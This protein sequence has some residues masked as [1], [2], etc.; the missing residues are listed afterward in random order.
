MSTC[1]WSRHAQFRS[2]SNLSA[3]V[4]RYLESRIRKQ[5]I[6][7]N[8]VVGPSGPN[9]LYLQDQSLQPDHSDLQLQEINHNL[10][11]MTNLAQL[12]QLQTIMTFINTIREASLDNEI[13][14][15][16]ADFTS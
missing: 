2:D 6:Q 12:E 5:P 9:S 3:E 1:S 4:N 8:A 14:S 15:G 16:M 11:Y 7:V 10:R 13:A